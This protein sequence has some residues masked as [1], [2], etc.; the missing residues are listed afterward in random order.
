MSRRVPFYYGIRNS[1]PTASLRFDGFVELS[2]A[3]NPV[4]PLKT[5]GGHIER[6]AR[7]IGRFV[8]DTLYNNDGIRAREFKRRENQSRPFPT[9][10]SVMFRNFINDLRTTD[11]DLG[12]FRRGPS[13]RLCTTNEHDA[14]TTSDAFNRAWYCDGRA[15]KT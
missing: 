9:Q 13:S 5:V 7:E 8:E 14:C 10:R 1:V 2:N 15:R 12:E 6:S 4:F 3:F 11:V